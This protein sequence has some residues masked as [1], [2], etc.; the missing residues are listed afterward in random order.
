MP[1]PF[2]KGWNYLK[3]SLDKSVDDNADPKILVHQ[4]SRAVLA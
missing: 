4:A 2:A 3:A 1:N